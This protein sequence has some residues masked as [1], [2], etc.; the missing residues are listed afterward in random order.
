M[1]GVAAPAD[2]YRSFL[3]RL[4]GHGVG[5]ALHRMVGRHLEA[6]EVEESVQL[7]EFACAVAAE[8]GE[9][10]RAQRAAHEIL[11]AHADRWQRKLF[12][13]WRP[14]SGD[15]EHHRPQAIG[16]LGKAPGGG[17]ASFDDLEELAVAGGELDDRAVVVGAGEGEGMVGGER[18]V[19]GA[20]QRKEDGRAVFDHA[21]SLPRV[22]GG[23]SSDPPGASDRR[24]R[25]SHR[26]RP[27]TTPSSSR[28]P[29][30]IES[31]SPPAPPHP[32]GPSRRIRYRFAARPQHP[33]RSSDRI[34]IDSP[35][36]PVISGRFSRRIR[37]RFAARAARAIC[38]S[39]RIDIDSP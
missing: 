23:S 21:D 3:L 25:C 35:Q 8:Q 31:I 2:A 16:E 26:P 29:R 9:A 27:A 37:Y 13:R 22:G 30:W 6:V 24:R 10:D 7:G 36:G 33:A 34:D 1:Q 18:D 15:A 17:E 5:Q 4:V 19:A 28:W 11:R 14:S 38:S 39:G 20:T 32:R 12:R